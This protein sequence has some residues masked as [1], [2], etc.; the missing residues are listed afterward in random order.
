MKKRWFLPALVVAALVVGVQ[1]WLYFR[2]GSAPDLADVP[3]A[4]DEDSDESAEG[5]AS[6]TPPPPV[7]PERLGQVVAGLSAWRSPFSTEGQLMHGARVAGV[8]RLD[9]TLLGGGRRVAWLDGR[10]RRP[11]EKYG[12]FLV[13]SVDATTAVLSRAGR[14]Y[15]LE[16]QARSTDSKATEEE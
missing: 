7:S 5:G 1:N 14:S 10:P 6:D 16:V 12:D 2:G 4:A 11:G 3:W 15:T 9:G 8:P 13:V